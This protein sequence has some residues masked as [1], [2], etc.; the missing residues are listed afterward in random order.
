MNDDDDDDEED[1]ETTDN[2]DV[3]SDTTPER[4]V[5]STSTLGRKVR[6]ESVSSLS[7]DD[8]R[9]KKTKKVRDNS[10]SPSPSPDRVVKHN[11]NKWWKEEKAHMKSKKVSGFP[12]GV[13]RD[14]QARVTTY[15]RY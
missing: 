3:S 9:V 6:Q 2:D 1:S 4:R 13:S 12:T 5:R 14:Y 7:L 10:P 15:D 11:S 8:R